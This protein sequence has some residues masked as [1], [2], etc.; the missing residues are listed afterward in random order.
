MRKAQVKISTF[1][2]SIVIVA[3]FVS[4]FTSFY[5]SI[6]TKYTQ[7]FDTETNDSLAVYNQFAIIENTTSNINQTLFGT[8]TGESGVT[9]ILGK[10]LGSGFNTLKIAKESFKAFYLI[11]NNASEQMGLPNIFVGSLTLIVLIIIIFIIIRVLVG[12]DV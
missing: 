1:L 5:A 7:A 4:T 2:I 10:F 12:Q 6:S 3:L 9:D 8:S 11:A